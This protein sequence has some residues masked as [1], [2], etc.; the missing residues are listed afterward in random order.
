MLT[1]DVIKNIHKY[2][3]DDSK[4]GTDKILLGEHKKIKKLGY[5]LGIGKLHRV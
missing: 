4:M 2:T 3:P 1:H 5:I